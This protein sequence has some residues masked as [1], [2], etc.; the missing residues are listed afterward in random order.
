[1]PRRVAPVESSAPHFTKDSRARLFTSCGSTRSQ[2]SQMEVKC[3]PSSRAAMIDRTAPSPTFLT[4]FRPK[5]IFAST[6]AKSCA[7]EFTSGGSI[8]EFARTIADANDPV[9]RP[10]GRVRAGAVR[11]G[12]ARGREAVAG[13]GAFTSSGAATRCRG[14]APGLEGRRPPVDRR[15]RVARVAGGRTSRASTC[16]QEPRLS[17]GPQADHRGN[18]KMHHNHFEAIQTVQKL[19]LPARRKDTEAVEVV[20]HPPF[21][22]LRSVQT[23]IESDRLPFAL[24]AQN[25]PLGGE[26]R[27]HRRGRAADARRAQGAR[28]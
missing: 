16:L 25:C 26:G 4:A 20:V 9:E 19:G 18:W 2:K 12:N 8:E 17:G 23:L 7:E 11:G 6:T 5:R 24:G 1:M 14:Q 22:G 15:R 3:P 21:T 27:L 13:T 10:D 28:T